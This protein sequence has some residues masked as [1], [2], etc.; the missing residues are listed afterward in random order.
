MS[1]VT[2]LFG[3]L[4]CLFRWPAGS[5]YAA[6]TQVPPSTAWAAPEHPSVTRRVSHNSSGTSLHLTP[7]PDAYVLLWPFSWL[8][9]LGLWG[10]A[11]RFGLCQWGKTGF[12]AVADHQ[13]DSGGLIKG[14]TLLQPRIGFGTCG[15]RPAC[16][17]YHVQTGWQESIYAVLL[18]MGPILVTSNIN[19][20]IGWKLASDVQ[21]SWVCSV[22]LFFTRNSGILFILWEGFW[23]VCSASFVLFAGLFLS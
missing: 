3:S 10:H 9:C 21:I 13:G 1:A 18:Q 4:D 16:K 11:G 22:S 12:R 17:G 20:S 23:L 6:D 19:I 7:V 2:S 15:W 8:P 14:L 5:P